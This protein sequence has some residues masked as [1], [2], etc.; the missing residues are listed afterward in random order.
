MVRQLAE[1][2]RDTVDGVDLRRRIAVAADERD[3]AVVTQKRDVTDRRGELIRWI[4]VKSRD[5]STVGG[6]M[7]A[8]AASISNSTNE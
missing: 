4:P 5:S 7:R 3:G 8:I 1:L 2:S 6:A